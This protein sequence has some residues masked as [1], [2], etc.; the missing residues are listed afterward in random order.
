MGRDASGTD[1][2]HRAPSIGIGIG[3]GLHILGA[4]PTIVAGLRV[5]TARA[6]ATGRQANRADIEPMVHM[7]KDGPPEHPLNP[8]D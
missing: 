2:G 4:A 8:A 3:I 6:D 1:I 5:W 7:L